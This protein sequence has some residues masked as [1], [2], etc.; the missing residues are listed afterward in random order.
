MSNFNFYRDLPL[1]TDFQQIFDDN[2][3]QPVPPDW[4]VVITDVIGSTKAIEE[5]R[6]KDVNIA[7]GIAT[8]AVSNLYQDLDYP[9]IFGGD[10]ITFLIPDQILGQVKDVLADTRKMCREHFKLDLR[11]GFLRVADIYAAGETLQIAKLKV[12]KPYNQA[13]VSGGGLDY[14]EGKLKSRT[15]GHLYSIAEDYE[16]K[17]KANFE[18]FTCRWQDVK[19]HKGETLSII[20][21][22]RQEADKI[23][24]K[25]IFDKIQEFFGQEKDY[26]PLSVQNIRYNEDEARFA[27]EAIVLSGQSQGAEYQKYL[28]RAKRETFFLK[29]IYRLGLDVRFGK[30]KARALEIKET[31]LIASDFRK[32]DGTLKMVVS[33]TTENRLRLAEYL[34]GVYQQGFIYYGIHAS[35]RALMTCLMYEGTGRE[36]HFIDSAEGGYAF[37]ARQLKKQLAENQSK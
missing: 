33:C 16:P 31:N 19:S 21:K 34:E 12:S 11:I 18:G 28:N 30:Q 25:Q 9:F 27:K 14:A 20:V 17:Q 13:I 22:L 32:Y 26:H 15:E 5:G 7:G 6:Y 2:I 36:V 1:I 35:D 10:G 8:M 37:A 29:W 23:L 3:Y 4:Y 24:L